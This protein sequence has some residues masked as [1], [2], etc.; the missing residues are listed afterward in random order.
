MNVIICREHP[1]PVTPEPPVTP[2]PLPDF[3]CRHEGRYPNPKNC[4]AYFWCLPG[5]A[6]QGLV[7]HTFNCPSG[8]IITSIM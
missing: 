6:G 1:T 3:D 7:S 8:I 2:S 4:H 5:S